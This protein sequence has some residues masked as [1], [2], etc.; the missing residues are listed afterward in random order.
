VS[1]AARQQGNRAARCL[2][3]RRLC[4][5]FVVSQLATPILLSRRRHSAGVSRR[6]DQRRRFRSAAMRSR[7]PIGVKVLQAADNAVAVLE[8]TET[9]ERTSRGISGVADDASGAAFIGASAAAVADAAAACDSP[10]EH[11]SPARSDS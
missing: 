5:Y 3:A 6:G 7:R 8:G 11:E 4:T 10:S 1:L 2:V 9:G